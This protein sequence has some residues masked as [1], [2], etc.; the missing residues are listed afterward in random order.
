MRERSSHR[1]RRRRPGPPL[2]SINPNGAVTS[3]RLQGN[4]RQVDSYQSGGGRL[5]S[6]SKDSYTSLHKPRGAASMHWN[7]EESD[8]CN[9]KEQISPPPRRPRA[10]A[11]PSPP[12]DK[13]YHKSHFY[14][15][16]RSPVPVKVPSP[17]TNHRQRE[18]GLISP[19]AHND[20]N[21][22]ARQSLPPVKHS[23]N[24]S[25]VHH[26]IHGGTQNTG[27]VIGTKST[28]R[29]SKYFRMYES[30][31]QTKSLLGQDCLC[32]NVHEKQGAYSGHVYDASKYKDV[33]SYN[34]QNNSGTK[35][36]GESKYYTE[37]N[38]SKRYQQNHQPSHT[39]QKHRVE[40]NYDMWSTTSRASYQ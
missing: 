23:I 35:V 31:N 13:Y 40:E 6:L 37:K 24:P 21:H 33:V 1:P 10:A 34:V 38:R 26:H 17:I 36:D 19:Q 18:I 11:R 29:Q 32:W 5:G 14:A 39:Y 8:D 3:P 25:A 28:V 15:P 20:H 22:Q 30:G 4:P 2:P 12:P 27:N 16:S 7:K 9:E